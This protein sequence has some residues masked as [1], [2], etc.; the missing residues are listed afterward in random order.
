[1][2]H[3]RSVHKRSNESGAW[4]SSIGTWKPIGLRFLLNKAKPHNNCCHRPTKTL[5]V[6]K[7]SILHLSLRLLWLLWL[8]PLALVPLV[9]PP[10]AP[11]AP[12]LGVL[13]L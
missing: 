13:V 4:S 1:M 9:L 12:V 7:T 11:L 10:L 8:V 6:S 3:R 2:I 5:R